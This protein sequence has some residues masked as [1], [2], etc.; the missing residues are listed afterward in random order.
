LYGCLDVFALLCRDRP[1]GL[2]EGFGIVFL[3]AAACG[4]AQVAGR[5]GGA[6]DAVVDGVTG[7]VVDR[8]ADVAAVAAAL[9]RLLG[10]DG[11][12]QRMGAAAR[13]R[14]VAEFTYDHLS[15]RLAEALAG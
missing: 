5:S 14:V 12:R 8:P 4:V 3:E 9:A 2:E 11:A 13:Q 1:G 6:T 7:V 15:G 10:D